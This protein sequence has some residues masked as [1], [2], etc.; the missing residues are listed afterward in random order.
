MGING[1]DKLILD[2]RNWI[3]F[4]CGIYYICDWNVV[5]NIFD[6]GIVKLV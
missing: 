1:M 4:N 2:D 3:C 5:K 6:K